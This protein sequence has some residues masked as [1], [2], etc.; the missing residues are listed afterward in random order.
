MGFVSLSTAGAT[1]FWFPEWAPRSAT[2]ASPVDLWEMQTAA[3]P[4]PCKPGPARAGAEPAAWAR[5][6]RQLWCTR[7][8]ADHRLLESGF[9]VPRNSYL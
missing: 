3:Q 6:S 1:E 4:R 9:A 2:P 5:L 7:E 8:L